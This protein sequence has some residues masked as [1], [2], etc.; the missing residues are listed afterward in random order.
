[1]HIYISF[2]LNISLYSELSRALYIT[3]CMLNETY[4]YKYMYVWK[5]TEIPRPFSGEIPRQFCGTPHMSKE[6]SIYIYVCGN[7]PRS[8][9]FSAVH[10]EC[11]KKHIYV[12]LWK[13]RS[14]NILPLAPGACTS[15]QARGLRTGLSCCWSCTYNVYVYVYIYI[16]IYMYI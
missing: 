4:I 7:T 15:G 8:Q 3:Q 5:Q 16:Y 1:M 14:V 9:G 6:T 11:Q 2:C 12:Y 10:R 13:V